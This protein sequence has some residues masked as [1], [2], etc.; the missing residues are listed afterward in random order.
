MQS[1][2]NKMLNAGALT[3]SV[4]QNHTVFL[5]FLANEAKDIWAQG[6]IDLWDQI[7]YD[8][9]W[10]DMNEATGFCNGECPNGGGVPTEPEKKAKI[11]K[12]K[13]T[14]FLEEEA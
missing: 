14:K 10:L 5:D 12:E 3:T 2:I 4:W 8:G 11:I 7:P 1:T 6:L 9:I 13:I